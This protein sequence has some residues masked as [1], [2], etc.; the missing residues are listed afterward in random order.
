MAQAL[1]LLEPSTKGPNEA[2]F[3]A[4]DECY[5]LAVTPVRR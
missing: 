3:A 1:G 4:Y 2:F 5:R